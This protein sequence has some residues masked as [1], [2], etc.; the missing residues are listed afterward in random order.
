[1]ESMP[2]IGPSSD[3]KNKYNEIS[4]FCHEYIAYLL[5]TPKGLVEF[6]GVQIKLVVYNHD[7]TGN[8]MRFYYAG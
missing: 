3:L 7:L 5:A 6:T 1:M 4:D 8:I 2:V